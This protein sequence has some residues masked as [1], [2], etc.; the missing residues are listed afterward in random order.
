VDNVAY[1]TDHWLSGP[2][3]TERIAHRPDDHLLV[4]QTR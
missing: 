1:F 4:G 2:R 3:R